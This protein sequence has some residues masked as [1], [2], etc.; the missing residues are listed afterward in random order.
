[1]K[2][3]ILNGAPRSGKGEFSKYIGAHQESMINDVKAIAIRDY[4]WDGAKTDQNRQLLSNIKISLD[5]QG[6][7]IIR[8]VVRRV[9]QIQETEYCTIDAREP[10]DIRDLVGIFHFLGL[11]VCTVLIRREAAEASAINGCAADRGVLEYDYDYEIRNDGALPEFW[12]AIAES[13][14]L[15]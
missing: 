1:M 4:G 8:G 7:S 3:I 5:S 2:I 9:L 15:E 14:V 6:R 13:G 12:Q 10:P 11:S